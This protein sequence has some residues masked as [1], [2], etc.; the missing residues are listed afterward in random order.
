MIQPQDL[1]P[2]TKPERRA[3]CGVRLSGAG[4]DHRGAQEARQGG[5]DCVHGNL[6]GHKGTV[7]LLLKTTE[8]AGAGPDFPLL[9]ALGL[10]PPPGLRSALSGHLTL[11]CPRLEP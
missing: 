8:Q 5:F 10:A 7:L 9:P 3:T 6:H 1:L 2:K 4:C 11:T